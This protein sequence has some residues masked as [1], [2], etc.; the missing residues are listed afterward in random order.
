MPGRHMF[1]SRAQWR[2]AFATHKPWARRWA[3]TNET[4]VAQGYR[5]IPPRKRAPSAGR[6]L[7]AL[8]SR[9]R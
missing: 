5:A 4:S 3:E 9:G 7:R 6:A 8:A 2:W 1:A